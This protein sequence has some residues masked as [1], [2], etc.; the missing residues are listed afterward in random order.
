MLPP[1]LIWRTLWVPFDEIFLSNSVFFWPQR[2]PTWERSQAFAIF[3]MASNALLYRVWFVAYNWMRN[4]NLYG[5]LFINPLRRKW[6]LCYYAFGYGSWRE[7]RSESVEVCLR[8]FNLTKSRQKAG[9]VS[10]IDCPHSSLFCTA[11]GDEVRVRIP[12]LYSNN[13]PDLLAWLS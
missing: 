8:F 9:I 12:L 7:N 1:V 6:W 4:Q 5:F 2:S 10:V 11:S 13:N 3:R